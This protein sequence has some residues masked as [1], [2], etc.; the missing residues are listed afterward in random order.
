MA[1][2]QGGSLARREPNGN[3]QTVRVRQRQAT[4]VATDQ[5][6]LVVLVGPGAGSC[7]PLSAGTT[8]LG[9]TSESTIQLDSDDISRHHAEVAVDGQGRHV[10]RD[11]GSKNGTRVNGQPVQERVLRFGDK[12]RLGRETV[13]IF[14]SLDRTEE[15]LLRS[16]RMETVG[17]IAAIVA[18]DFNNVLSAIRANLEYLRVVLPK[19]S[20]LDSPKVVEVLGDSD[21]AI[22]RAVELARQLNGLARHNRRSFHAVS[23]DE[24]VQE[25]A[26]L[27]R[28]TL[29]RGILVHVKH[30]ASP[31]VAGDAGQLHQVLT[32]LCVNARD[33]M[34]AGGNLTLTLDTVTLK[35]DEDEPPFLPGGDYAR[36]QVTDDGIGMPEEVRSRAFEP[37]FTTKERGKGT[38]LGLATVYGIVRKHGGA[39]SIE[40][41]V[42]R[43]TTVSV[44]LPR[45]GG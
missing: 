24:V 40:S 26:G 22:M 15:E 29:A 35:G 11:M 44:L 3:T 27:M 23:L 14:S 4:P 28:H 6:Q 39:V 38:G 31:T 43:G 36:I 1:V 33:A 34:P 16:Q 42:D 7:F 8:T 41:K 12:I 19:D 20:R 17:E 37:L 32:N 45:Q 30:A 5:A 10:L 25:V 9:R 13:I 21:Q 18:H 2:E